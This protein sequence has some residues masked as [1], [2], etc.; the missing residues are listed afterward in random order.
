V[1]RAEELFRIAREKQERM[2]RLE[3]LAEELLAVRVE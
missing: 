3:R 2:Q 1:A